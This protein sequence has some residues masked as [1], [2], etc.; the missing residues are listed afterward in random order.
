MEQERLKRLGEQG[1]MLQSLLAAQTW[2]SSHL[3][4]RFE[5]LYK[6]STG[7]EVAGHTQARKKRSEM[8]ELRV[9]AEL[10]RARLQLHV[11]NEEGHSSPGAR[12]R[13]ASVDEAADDLTTLPFVEGGLE[14]LGIVLEVSQSQEVHALLLLRDVILS[15]AGLRLQGGTPA[16]AAAT[17]AAA[18]IVA[19]AAAGV[20]KDAQP[21]RSR[22]PRDDKTR[23]YRQKP[24]APMPLPVPRSRVTSRDSAAAAPRGGAPR[25]AC[26]QWN[27]PSRDQAPSLE[28]FPARDHTP[29]CER[30]VSRERA[31]SRERVAARD[32]H[33]PFLDRDSSWRSDGSGQTDSFLV[34]ALTAEE[35][36]ERHEEALRQEEEEM[37][38]LETAIDQKEQLLK[39]LLERQSNVLTQVATTRGLMT[40]DRD[41][42][43]HPL[44]GWLPY[45]LAGWLAD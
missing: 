27:R 20:D 37:R 33:P 21:R 42:L 23:Q 40:I 14:N 22:A 35:E 2:R 19:A 30:M 5:R 10:H 3:N 45:L 11:R 34:A 16:A 43:T 7:R 38:A 15:G 1:G 28:R 41:S 31:V 6:A 9:T 39:D 36:Q 29:S 32:L 12:A 8:L 26:S 25:V 13:A 17:A 18:P 44:A 24:F 4:R